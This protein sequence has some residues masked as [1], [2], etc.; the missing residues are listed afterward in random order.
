MIVIEQE[1]KYSN[2]YITNEFFRMDTDYHWMYRSSVY[3]SSGTI[4]CYHSNENDC[5][6]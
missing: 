5:G 3:W 4:V 6:K 2:G 1:T